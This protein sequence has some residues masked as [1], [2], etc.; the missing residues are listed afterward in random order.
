[1]SFC[2]YV[3]LCIRELFRHH[4]KRSQETDRVGLLNEDQV[5]I[6]SDQ[7]EDFTSSSMDQHLATVSVSVHV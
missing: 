6:G 5:A 1:M 3:R 2:V 7:E 4:A